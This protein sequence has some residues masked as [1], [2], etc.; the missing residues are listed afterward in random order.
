MKLTRLFEECLYAPYIHVEN[1]GDYC[2]KARG[3]T[4]YIYLECSSGAIDWKNNLDFLPIAQKERMD[5]PCAVRSVKKT[6]TPT[7]PYK[8]MKT[9]W[10]A[11][12]GFLRVWQ[13]IAPYVAHEICNMRYRQIVTVGYSHGAALAV[14]CHEFI[15]YHRADL[16]ET[17]AGY[18][19]GCPRV[20]W[21]IL[22]SGARE[23]WKRFTV[24]RNL[25]D[26]VTHVPPMWLGF[27][28]VG[29]ML[30]VGTRGKYSAIDAHRPENILA[31]LKIWEN[32]E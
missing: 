26:I 23:R 24:I 16:R 13:S 6:C 20:Y 1:A 29:Q 19:F 31:E 7:A 25:D 32:T 27:S 11:H 5:V 21:G 14:L 22:G 10:F 28:H 8:E 2:M 3:N 30:T 9:R 17:L 4:L 15:W 18:G 12:R